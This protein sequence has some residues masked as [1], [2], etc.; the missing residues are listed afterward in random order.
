MT[1]PPDRR[2]ARRRAFGA[3]ATSLA[4]ASVVGV[5]L[6]M[7]AGFWAG[8]AAVLVGVGLGLM[9]LN[10]PGG[11]PILV[12]H[13][14]SPD[15]SWLPW[16]SN[17]SVRP[18]TLRRHL[19][20]L[21]R[22]GWTVISTRALVSK[23]RRGEAI[24][25]RAAVLHFDDGYLDNLVFAAP[26]LREF[27][28][29]ATFFVSTDFIDPSQALR[30]RGDIA[31]ASDHR[32]YMNAAELRFLDAD[33]LFDVEA[34]GVDHARVP[35]SDQAGEP[36]DERNWR[37]HV[38]LAWAQDAANKS[39]WFEAD[40][41]PPPLRLGEPAPRT[42]SA[43]TGRWRR[44]GETESEAAFAQRVLGALT[45]AREELTSILG[46]APW[47]FAW[48]F[49]RSC[50][51]SE[52]LARDAG[53]AVLTGG[54]GENRPDE[55]PTVLSRVHVT[56]RAF[57]GGPGWLEELALTARVHAASGRYAWHGVVALASTLRRR[58]FGR[59]GYEAAS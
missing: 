10:R 23:R 3:A 35:V 9:A 4:A 32:G 44:G 49:D 21:R 42:D 27:E 22:G 12:Y 14:V 33:P 8:A 2:A 13:S 5:V 40:H 17:T 25:P 6:G 54:L 56:D 39:R 28:A 53:F 37:R 47:V 46:R 7:V 16:A 50:P 58:R 52:I 57:G 1:T 31:G 43:L 59:P 38:P 26:I 41:P 55:D 18:E 29:P 30:H 45:H 19:R 48:P 15:A 20:A 11:V 24:E 36:V 51:T 34:H